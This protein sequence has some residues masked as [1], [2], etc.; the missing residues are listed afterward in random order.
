MNNNL[1]IINNLHSIETQHSPNFQIQKI[2]FFLNTH[3]F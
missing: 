1:Y 2:V 3:D